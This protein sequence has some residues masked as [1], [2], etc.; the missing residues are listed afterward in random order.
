MLKKENISPQRAADMVE[1]GMTIMIGGF[2]AVGTPEKIIDALVE[3]GVGNLTIIA[4][5]T[6]LS[7]GGSAS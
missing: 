4:N 2:M 1:E 5:D 7:I 3:K 6:G